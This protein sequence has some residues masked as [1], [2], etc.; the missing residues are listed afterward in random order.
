MSWTPPRVRR[1]VPSGRRGFHRAALAAAASQRWLHEPVVGDGVGPR[2]STQ[3][4]WLGHSARLLGLAPELERTVVEKIVGELGLV[5]SVHAVLR[6]QHAAS[7]SLVGRGR[8]VVAVLEQVRVTEGLLSRVL[9]AGHLAGLWGEP[10]LC[11]VHTGQRF[12]PLS[13]EG[14]WR[15]GPPSVRS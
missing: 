5:G 7:G 8:A 6:R 2:Y 15:R 14:R 3:R 9:A 4:R 10:W 11:D 1:R 12:S 13:S